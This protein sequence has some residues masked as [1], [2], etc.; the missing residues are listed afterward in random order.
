MAFVWRQYDLYLRRY[1]KK[2]NLTLTVTLKESPL[3]ALTYIFGLESIGSILPKTCFF[4]SGDIFDL[5]P[6]KPIPI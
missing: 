2:M 6:S 1:G 4:T 3:L 5:D